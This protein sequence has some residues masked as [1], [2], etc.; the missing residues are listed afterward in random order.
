MAFGSIDLMY[1]GLGSIESSHKIYPTKAYS[2]V[3]HALKLGGGHI[4]RKIFRFTYKRMRNGLASLK[5]VMN[6]MENSSF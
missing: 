4:N 3:V 6:F 2:T 5:K 1:D